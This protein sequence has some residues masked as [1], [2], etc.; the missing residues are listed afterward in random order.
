M[1]ILRRTA[2]VLLAGILLLAPLAATASLSQGGQQE[3]TQIKARLEQLIAAKYRQAGAT[4]VSVY[5]HELTMNPEVA[6]EE[7]FRFSPASLMKVPIM[8]AY[9]RLAQDDPAVLSRRLT[10][11]GSTDYTATQGIKPP[12]TLKPG[13]AYTVEDLLRRMIAYS[14]NNALILLYGNIDVRNIATLMQILGVEYFPSADGGRISLKSYARFYFSLYEANYLNRAMSNRA[15]AYLEQETFD[16]GLAS[17]IP[18]GTRIAAK[19]GEW[20]GGR[21]SEIRQ[22]SEVGIVYYPGHPYLIGVA[23]EGRD[24]A[25]LSSLIQDISREVYRDI[26]LLDHPHS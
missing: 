2:I 10:F 19:F 1:T 4:H 8:M 13:T 9:L 12:E 18:R 26:A 16:A 6:I 3:M 5:F 17:G 24:I 25:S 15:L 14:D 7:N 20:A 22:L 21:H 23:V 11:S